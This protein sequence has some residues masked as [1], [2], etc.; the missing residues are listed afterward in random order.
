MERW[1]N[2]AVSGTAAWPTQEVAVQFGGHELLLRPG[3]NAKSQSIHIKLKGISHE[4]GITLTN[5]FLSALSW[6]D[7]QPIEI[8]FAWSGSPMPAS[9]EKN[10]LDR[11]SSIAFPFYREMEAD[12]KALLALALY[13][14][15]RTIKSVPLSFLSYF[16]ILNI[17]WED[18]FR[19]VGSK[20]FNPIIEGMRD[21]LP[22]VKDDIA[23][24]RISEIAG[25]HPD[26]AAYL[27][28]SCRCA[29]AHAN[30]SPIVDPDRVEDIQRLSIDIDIVKEIASSKM[31]QEFKLSRSI[32]K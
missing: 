3:T 18:K 16:K 4:D 6:C 12:P 5:R 25:S 8:T 1:L 28:E 10:E 7:D 15:G 24:K 20:R 11:G 14:E 9:M 13:R 32:I 23:K 17:F 21:A 31:T 27:Y 29:V 2:V 19:R 26:V 22:T 30:T